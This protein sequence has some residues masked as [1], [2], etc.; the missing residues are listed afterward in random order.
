MPASAE[1]NMTKFVCSGEIDPS[2][3]ENSV[4]LTPVPKTKRGSAAKKLSAKVKTSAKKAAK[5][6]T[7]VKTVAKKTVA[8]AKKTAAK[9]KTEA[10]KV[11]K[12]EGKPAARRKTPAKNVTSEPKQAVDPHADPEIEAMIK[13]LGL[14]GKDVGRVLAET[15]AHEVS[16]L[17]AMW[18][19]RAAKAKDAAWLR[20]W[21]EITQRIVAL[22][23]E[24]DAE[25]E[26]SVII[27][28][29]A[30]KA[31]EVKKEAVETKQSARD[32]ARNKMQ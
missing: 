26:A 29:E 11:T 15:L 32:R 30:G 25:P 12:S 5:P 14:D 7:K 31:P 17:R 3:A 23:P 8:K 9:P 4:K 20:V 22:A 1:K 16:M 6:R 2:T 10:K 21:G 28:P 13:L 19:L 27:E 18:A 24:I